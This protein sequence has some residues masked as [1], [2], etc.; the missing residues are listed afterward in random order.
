MLALLTSPL[1]I[2]VRWWHW[3]VLLPELGNGDPK[4]TLKRAQA[5]AGLL[6]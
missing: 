1:G 4:V 3:T 6:L 2:A 5:A